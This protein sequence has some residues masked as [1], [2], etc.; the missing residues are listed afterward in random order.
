MPLKEFHAVNLFLR[1]YWEVIFLYHEESFILSRL[2]R[3]NSKQ[4]LTYFQ[5]KIS[6]RKGGEGTERDGS[7]LD[8]TGG[9]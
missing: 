1:Y 7:G 2:G 5:I 4:D 6:L 9:G 3:N 8:G